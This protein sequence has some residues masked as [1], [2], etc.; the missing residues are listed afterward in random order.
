MIEIYLFDGLIVK[1]I[2]SII[3]YY[4]IFTMHFSAARMLYAAARCIIC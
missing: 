3:R 1:N 2:L 4:A